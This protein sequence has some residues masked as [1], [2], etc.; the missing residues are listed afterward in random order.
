M[1]SSK[2][3]VRDK[4]K[5]VIQNGETVESVTFIILKQDVY[6]A[7]IFYTESEK[8]YKSYISYLVIAVWS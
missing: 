2:Q 4:L 1:L 6:T 5:L 7:N 8:N 3:A